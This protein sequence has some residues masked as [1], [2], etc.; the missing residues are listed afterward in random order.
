MAQR[1]EAELAQ[2]LWDEAT[3]A[4]QKGSARIHWVMGQLGWVAR[5]DERSLRKLLHTTAKM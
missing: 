2:R 1:D 3:A 4:G 5:T